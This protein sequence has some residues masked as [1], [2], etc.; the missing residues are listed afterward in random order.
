MYRKFNSDGSSR[1]LVA[2]DKPTRG[3]SC[4]DHDFIQTKHKLESIVCSS[5]I[6]DHDIVIAGIELKAPKSQ[7]KSSY[8]KID[9]VWIDLDV[10]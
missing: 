9:M 2:N 8:T 6:I 5:S 1:F 3:N 4:L 10:Q 7:R